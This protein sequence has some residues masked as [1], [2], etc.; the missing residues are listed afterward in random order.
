MAVKEVPISVLPYTKNEEVI[1]GIDVDWDDFRVLL[2]VVRFKSFNRAAAALGLTQPTVSRR[3]ERLEQ[4]FHHQLV[5]RT[6]N[7]AAITYEGQR[8]VEEISLAH[9]ALTRAMNSRGRP[10]AKVANDPVRLSITDGI[11]TYWFS[12]FLSFIFDQS[13]ELELQIFTNNAFPNDERKLLDLYVHYTTPADMENVSI[14]L[15]TLHFLPYASPGYL[16]AFGTP[17]AP[18]DLNSHRLLDFSMYLVDKGSWATRLADLPGLEQTQ[19]FTNSS[20]VMGEAIRKGVGIGLLP[21]YASVFEEGI[22][23]LDIGLQYETPVWLSYRRDAIRRWP[24]RQVVQ[25]MRAMIDKKTMPWFAD[26]FV[27][28]SEFKAIDPK[29]IIDSIDIVDASPQ[30]AALA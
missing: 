11:A 17:R 28:P 7:G 26:K 12:R 19:L 27:H 25:Y 3:I 30:Q 9:A 5:E 29:A 21:T 10:N 1:P 24:V 6:R 18:A 4:A 8:V 20:P 14:R 16:E 22:V 15:G 23:P 2:A 13:P